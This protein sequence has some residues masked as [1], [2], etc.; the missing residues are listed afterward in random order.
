MDMTGGEEWFAFDV[1]CRKEKH[2][3][4][5]QGIG[6]GGKSLEIFLLL[7]I[8]VTATPFRFRFSISKNAVVEKRKRVSAPR[9]IL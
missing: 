5:V 8:S 6:M 1:G 2:N 7:L 4:A 9:M 3:D